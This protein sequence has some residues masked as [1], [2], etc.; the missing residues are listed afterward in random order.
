MNDPI[1]KEPEDLLL[2][3]LQDEIS[4]EPEKLRDL[5]TFNQNFWHQFYR[6]IS[7]EGLNPFAFRS[8]NAFRNA[9]SVPDGLIALLTESYKV[10]LLRDQ[11]RINCFNRIASHFFENGIPF[12]PVK[13][14]ALIQSVYASTHDRCFND[15]DILVDE[16]QVENAS[17]ILT[18]MGFKMDPFR[19][20]WGKLTSQYLNHHLPPFRQESLIIELHYKLLPGPSEDFSRNFLERRIGGFRVHEVPKP[21]PVYH[22][23]FLAAHWHKHAQSGQNQLRLIRDLALLLGNESD[24]WEE[25]SALS[26]VFNLKPAVDQARNEFL[27]VYQNMK[28][29]NPAINTLPARTLPGL[30]NSVNSLPTWRLKLYWILDLVFPSKEYIRR[31]YPNRKNQYLF[32]WHLNRIIRLLF[33]LIR[34]RAVARPF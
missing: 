2:R 4:P 13:G 34:K 25:T 21:E 10:N 8:L 24:K 18:S 33:K 26:T 28:I 15:M 17:R 11:I 7:Q 5:P 29:D 30:L 32:S 31:R 6:L 9:N 27:R 12:V 3:L 14:I 1:I 16:E 20:E 19:S 23:V 22:S